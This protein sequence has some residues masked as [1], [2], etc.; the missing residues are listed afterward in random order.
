ML[1]KFPD[2]PEALKSGMHLWYS[3]FQMGRSTAKPDPSP[4]RQSLVRNHEQRGQQLQLLLA[5]RGPLI[6]GSF[7]R[8]GGRC[9][10]PSCRCARGELHERAVLYTSEQGVHAGTYVPQDERAQVEERNA[11]YQRFRK[12]RS[13]LAKLDQQ[14]RLFA[15]QLFEALSEPYPSPDGPATGNRKRARR[16]SS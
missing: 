7:I 4:L 15:D 9:G 3:A 12:A 6:R 1:L 13:G 14:A 11:R 8:Q 16:R 2:P 10:K 5:E